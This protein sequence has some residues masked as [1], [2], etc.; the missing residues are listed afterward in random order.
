[1]TSASI[2]LDRTQ[3]LA[4][5]V[6][7]T[8]P[9]QI[10]I[11]FSNIVTNVRLRPCI[12]RLDDLCSS[13]V[14]SLVLH[15]VVYYFSGSTEVLPSAEEN[16]IFARHWGFSIYKESNRTK[17]VFAKLQQSYRLSQ[18]FRYL[19]VTGFD[20]QRYIKKVSLTHCPPHIE[21][22]EQ[23]ALRPDLHVTLLVRAPEK[24]FQHALCHLN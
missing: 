12:L 4:R 13:L 17:S 16:Y 11:C 18:R 15:F 10:D 1:M 9:P 14:Y 8:L 5:L 6:Q 21:W 20:L 24:N 19:C 3:T 22:V 2:V 23:T 7:L